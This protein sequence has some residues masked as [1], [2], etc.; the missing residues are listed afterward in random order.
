MFIDVLKFTEH[1]VLWSLIS[2]LSNMKSTG[3][4]YISL[5]VLMSK[6]CDYT[7]LHVISISFLTTPAISWQSTS[8]ATLSTHCFLRL[9]KQN[10]LVKADSELIP[11]LKIFYSSFRFCHY[12]CCN[13]VGIC[14]AYLCLN[15]K[16]CSV[17]KVNA[18]V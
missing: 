11:S 14:H 16:N 7:K 17:L 10:R 3:D 2:Y 5:L 6:I 18:V 9:V 1:Y 13:I 8:T 4:C 15:L 12:F